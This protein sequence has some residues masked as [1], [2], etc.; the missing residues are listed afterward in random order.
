MGG[1]ACGTAS[2]LTP[3]IHAN[4]IAALILGFLPLLLPV[5]GPEG[6]AALLIGTL[7]THSFLELIPAAF[8]GVPAEG[9]SLMTLPAHALTL[10]GKG[11]EAVRVSALGSLWGVIFSIPLALA[12]LW[13]LPVLE[14]PVDLFTGVLLVLIMG[15][16]IV[17]NETPGWMLGILLVSGLVG[18]FAFRYD[19]LSWNPGSFGSV[20]MPLLMGLFGLPVLLTSSGGAIPRQHFSGIGI[21][22]ASCIRSAIPGTIA[23]FVVGWLPGLSTASANALITGL[24]PYDKERRGYLV[25]SAASTTANAVL[26]IAVF[27]AIGRTRNGVMAVFSAFETPSVFILITLAAITAFCA[28]IVTI[29]CAG[30]APRLSGLNSSNLNT[31]VAVFLVLVCGIMTGPF[32]LVILMLST[33]IGF[34]PGLLDISRVSCMGA[35]TV[36][37]ILYSFGVGVF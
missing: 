11:E 9:T 12:A 2:G 23:G 34:V 18:I 8:L 19:Y 31:C 25:A 17:R 29:L 28:Y 22:Q 26:G 10:E 36:P 4:T 27:I 30:I 14:N 13:V 16:V 15:L 3:G 21:S 5:F 7:I 35:V 37:V 20:L 6:M 1:I 32:G 33:A 24:I